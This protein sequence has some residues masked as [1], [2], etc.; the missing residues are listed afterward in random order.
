MSFKKTGLRPAQAATLGLI[1]LT[2]Q[3]SSSWAVEPII[4]S[5]LSTRS[6]GMGGVSMTTGF[7]E[8][9]FFNNP[10]RVIAN[11]ESKLTLF[12]LTAE[13]NTHLIKAL[14]NTSG[15]LGDIANREVGQNLHERVQLVLP[16]WY[17]AAQGGRK[18]A[19][20]FGLIASGQSNLNLSNSYQSSG[21]TLVDL[22]PALTFGYNVLN[23]DSLW[24]G[25]TLHG[26]ARLSADHA[27]NLM[28]IIRGSTVNL[29][30]LTNEGAM[31]NFDFGV[32]YR[33]LQVGPWELH[34]AAAGQNL[35]GGAFTSI[36]VSLFKV[37][38]SPIKQNRSL[39]LGIS[40]GRES[41]GFLGNTLLAIEATN[42][43]NNGSG[44]LY[45]LLHVGLETH[46]KSIALRAGLNQGYWTAGLGLDFFYFALNFASYGEE[47]G[48]NVG[49][50]EDRRYT[51]NLGIHF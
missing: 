45:R 16:A 31:Y 18:F 48:L 28:N 25:T 43:W 15:T 37:G 35:L 1:L 5:F 33:F 41:W 44:S 47:L 12:Q 49:Q 46:W 24:I 10:A 50:Q 11:P 29:S 32:Y 14:S 36:P 38:S 40:V 19:I 34:A 26:T 7:Y 8:E 42:I 27:V 22:G 39:G 2:T 23:D 21:S 3:L 30:S 9:N 17:L 4:N 51:M 13:S 20:A 6:E